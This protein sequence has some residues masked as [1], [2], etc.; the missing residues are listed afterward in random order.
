MEATIALSIVF[1]ASEI[2]HR[3][4]GRS[5]IAAQT[6]WIVAF[7]FGLLHGFGFAGAL[8]AVGLPQNHIPAA[9]FFFNVGVEIGQIAFIAVVLT[10]ITLV[11]RLPL[12][13]PRWAELIPPYAIGSVAMLWVIQRVVA[14]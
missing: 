1:V 11:R 10:F 12:R 3:R 5:G 2:L 13:V 9:L 8:S 6:P 7:T 4:G 14:F